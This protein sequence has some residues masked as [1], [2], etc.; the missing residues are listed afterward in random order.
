MKLSVVIP[1]YNERDTLERVVAAVRSAPVSS[2]E[3][4]IVDDASTD[5]TAELLRD[6][7]S[8]IVERII[9][10]E[11]N[12]GKGAALR[13]GFRV[14]TGDIVIIQ[15]A[16]LEYDPRDYARLIEPIMSRS[17]DVVFGS[18]LTAMSADGVVFSWHVVGNK[19]LT[20]LSN[21]LT[22]LSLTDME[23]GYKAFRRDVIQSIEIEEDGFGV[24]PEIT[25]KLAKRGVAIREVEI[26]YDR[27]SYSEGKKV[28]WRDGIWAVYA[29][30]K[31][32]LWWD[33]GKRT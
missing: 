8:G 19:L 6:K 23:T 9:Y 2:V 15:D 32:N 20:S 18:R 11:T 30:L 1:C 12:Q 14:A 7:L 26:S 28:R 4:I 10:H 31:Y 3:I 29:I 24:E 25:A 33:G 22:K 5:G 16:D 21:A 13:S 27:R 17:A